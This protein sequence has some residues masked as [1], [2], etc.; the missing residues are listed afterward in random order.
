MGDTNKPNGKE[1]AEEVLSSLDQ[2][3]DTV[4]IEFKTIHV[5]KWK[6]SIRIGSL[7]AEDLISFVETNEQPKAKRTAGIRL[8]VKSMVDTDGNRIGRD[9]DIA[10]LQ[11]KNHQIVTSLIDEVMKLNGLGKKDQEQLKN[12]SSEASTDASPTVLH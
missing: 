8:L 11:R 7:S 1:E 2:I 6:M 3:V 12:V 5:P 10:I 4:D 9:T